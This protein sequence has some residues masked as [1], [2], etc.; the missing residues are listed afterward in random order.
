MS[1][2]KPI[3][4]HAKYYLIDLAEESDGWMH[5]LIYKIIASNGHITEDEQNEIISELLND[6]EKSLLSDITKDEESHETTE[7]LELVELTHKSGV[8]ALING[9]KISF[10]KDITLINGLN[11]SGK[12]SYFRILNRMIGNEKSK[13]L[14]KNIYQPNDEKIDAIIKYKI[15]GNPMEKNWEL[16][17]INFDDLKSISVFDSSDVKNVLI[18]HSPNE[19][20]LKPYGLYLFD[21]LVKAVEN[22]KDKILREKDTIESNIQFID[23]NGFQDNLK[24]AISDK[25]VDNQIQNYI[26]ERFNYTNLDKQEYN[27][28]QGEINQILQP[29]QS[30]KILKNQITSLK[31]LQVNIIRIF[32]SIKTASLEW[33]KNYDNT[34]KAIQKNIEVKEKISILHEIENSNNPEWKDFIRAGHKYSVLYNHDLQTCPYCRQTLSEKA[35]NILSAYKNYLADSSERELQ[36]LSKRKDVIQKSIKELNIELNTKII[37]MYDLKNKDVL[38]NEID[39][40]SG[41]LKKDRDNLINQMYL[42]K[43]ETSSYVTDEGNLRKLQNL[44]VSAINESNKKLDFLESDAKKKIELLDEYQKLCAELLEKESIAK[45]EKELKIWIDE[46]NEI[47]HLDNR[48][49]QLSTNRI[50]HKAGIAAKE[51]I[52]DSLKNAFQFYLDELYLSELYVNLDT[53]GNVKGQQQLKVSL[54]K[55]HN[56]KINDILSEGELKG[57]ALALYLAERKIQGTNY[58]IILDDPVDSLDKRITYFFLKKLI[59]LDNQIIIFS[60]DPVVFEVLSSNNYFNMELKKEIIIY[61]VDCKGGHRAGKITPYRKNNIYLDLQ[62][63]EQELKKSDSNQDRIQNISERL[64]LIVERILDDKYLNIYTPLKLRMSG[65]I[66]W[67]LIEKLPNAN[68]S[69]VQELHELYK[70]LSPQVHIGNSSFIFS[71]TEPVIEEMVSKLRK[72][73][74]S[75]LN[76]K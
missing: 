18:N 58:P 31:E 15:N 29:A 71:I 74:K 50:S 3:Y 21:A 1:D 33:Y 38:K 69:D 32:S 49:Q 46:L 22:I 26:E 48:I 25:K 11:G 4:G 75:K 14:I 34:A 67:D 36:E 63:I 41:F 13:E 23:T 55:A 44:I 9:Q 45:Q 51:L 64:R 54:V 24:K 68:K 47:K 39:K 12:S 42:G 30:I 7:K 70:M 57:I 73:Y 37:E 16:G 76:E 2:Q 8:N 61:N 43:F 72:I 59:G 17:I 53:T 60:H 10:S 56:R 27:R 5:D 66:K 52:T 40:C 6:N 65:S 35:L 20:T 62:D 28:L 19:V